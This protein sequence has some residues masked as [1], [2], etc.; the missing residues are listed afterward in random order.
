MGLN[1]CPTSCISSA[2]PPCS[3]VERWAGSSLS[4]LKNLAF[5]ILERIHA[6]LSSTIANSQ[7]CL[8]GLK[9]GKCN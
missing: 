3:M 6:L 2:F 4:A 7:M 1:T 8:L 5:S 9:Y